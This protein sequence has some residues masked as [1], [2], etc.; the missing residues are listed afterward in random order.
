[1]LEPFARPS[2][3]PGCALSILIGSIFL[4]PALPAQLGPVGTQFWSQA[5]PDLEMSI[6]PGAQTGRA[7]AIG[8]FDCD[9]DGDLAIGMP[10][11]PAG[12]EAEAGRVLVL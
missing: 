8:D 7:L 3:S 12:G 1:M 9:G 5:S 2:C 4:T 6:E 11:D 10:G